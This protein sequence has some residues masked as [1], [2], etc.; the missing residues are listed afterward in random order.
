MKILVDMDDVLEPLAEHLCAELN[1]RHGTAV[2]RDD[3]TSWDIEQFFP[4]LTI[5]QIFAP[6]HE[7]SFW[8]AMEPKK[9]AARALKTLVEYGHTVRVVTASHPGT[10]KAKMDWLLN[11][12][13]C[14]K[15]ED[16]IIATDK[17]LI[18]GDV[19]IDDGVHNLESSKCPIKI[20]FD[21][22][23]NRNYDARANRMVRA[24][25]WADVMFYLSVLEEYGLCVL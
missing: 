11:A 2:Q 8:M 25:N 4:S 18:L 13:P 24:A 19:I 22:P 17:S 9:G 7:P 10:V 15:W 21:A 5:E 1:A 14:L 20:L 16:V 3:L 23:H 12:Y 6:L